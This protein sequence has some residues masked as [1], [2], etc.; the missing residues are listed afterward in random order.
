MI[1]SITATN[2]LGESLKIDLHRPEQSGLVIS[3]I[4]GLG[5]GDADVN[6]SELATIDGGMFNSARLTSRNVVMSFL[7][8]DDGNA[9][10]HRQTTYKYFPLKKVVKLTIETDTRI[11]ELSGI[12]ESNTHNIFSPTAGCTISIMCPDPYMYSV[13]TTT[14]SLSGIDPIFEFPFCDEIGDEDT[15]I[16]SDIRIIKDRSVYYVGDAD[17][18]VTINIHALGDVRDLV[19]YDT[20]TREKIAIDDAK[21]AALTGSS[22][23]ARDDIIISTVKGNKTVTLIRNGVSTNI[24]NAIDRNMSWFQLTKGDNIFTYTASTGEYNV[25]ISIKNRIRY[26]GV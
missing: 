6:I 24:I 11:A 25:Q 3:D 4:T 20:N 2:F 13:D 19:I 7:Y 14:T 10:K 18:G 9:D 23:S 8:Y 26:E 12:V 22:I 1:K 17:V 15:L 5:A 16:L 21:L